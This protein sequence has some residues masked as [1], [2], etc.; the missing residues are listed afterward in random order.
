MG[1]SDE[2]RKAEARARSKAWYHNNK[3][4]AR[5]SHRKWQEDNREK[6]NEYSR[7]WRE[8]NPEKRRAAWVKH[9]YSLTDEEYERLEAHDGICDSCQTAE[10]TDIDHCHDTGAVRGRLC[11]GCNV[12]LGMTDED[13][14]RLR[15]LADYIENSQ[16]IP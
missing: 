8:E 5:A 9:K 3:D 6:S 14:L 2:E 10:A 12:A 15:A 1:K 11:H 4:R 13:P 7:K 16:A